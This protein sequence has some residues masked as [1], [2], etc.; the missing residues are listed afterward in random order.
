MFR[1]ADA[2]ASDRAA[3]RMD[4]LAPL[5]NDAQETLVDI[6]ARVAPMIRNYIQ[7]SICLLSIHG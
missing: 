1:K 7:K 2:K 3:T 4:I 6:I 5:P